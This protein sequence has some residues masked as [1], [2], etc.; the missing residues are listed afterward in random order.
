M[1]KLNGSA[2]RLFSLINKVKDKLRAEKI[3]FAD[4]DSAIKCLEKTAAPEVNIKIYEHYIN[5]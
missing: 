3:D 2:K 5:Y 1:Y 4:Y